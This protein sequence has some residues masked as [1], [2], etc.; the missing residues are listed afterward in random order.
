MRPIEY[1]LYPLFLVGCLGLASGNEAQTNGIP[2]DFKLC[3]DYQPGFSYLKPWKVTITADGTA[4]REEY[5]FR[6]GNTVTAAED[7]FWLGKI[8]LQEL[9]A[10]VRES[11][12]Y[13]LGTNY[14]TSVTDKATV[15]L[16]VTMNSKTHEVMVYALSHQRNN[17][18]KRFSKLWNEVLKKVPSPNSRQKPRPS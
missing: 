2:S 10:I 12:F 4:V 7:I 11:D 16:Q 9:V 8:E 3:A 5:F 14:W 1:G 18:V 13:S 6:N 15:V 17:D